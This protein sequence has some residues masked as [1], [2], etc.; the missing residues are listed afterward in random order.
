MKMKERIRLLTARSN[1]LGNAKRK[2]A[3]RQYIIGW[4]NCYK[5]ADIKNLWTDIDE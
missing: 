3:L 1:G 2:E 5:I 4:V